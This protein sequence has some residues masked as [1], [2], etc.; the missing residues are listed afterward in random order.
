MALPKRIATGIIEAD[1]LIDVMER[2]LILAEKQ[3]ISEKEYRDFADEGF[4]AA[5]AAF[6]G[7]DGLQWL[8][9]IQETFDKK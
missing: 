2:F 8:I 4:T 6:Y 9:E 5:L 7:K 1:A 3:S